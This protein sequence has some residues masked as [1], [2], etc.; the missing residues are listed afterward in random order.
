MKKAFTLAEVLIT[1]TIIGVIA[2]ITIPNLMQ[3]WEDRSQITALKTAYSLLNNAYKMALAENG[4]LEDWAWPVPNGGYNTQNSGYFGKILSQ[5]LKVQKYCG[6]SG[7]CFN[8]IN[9]YKGISGQNQTRSGTTVEATARGA[10]ILNNGMRIQTVATI[11][12]PMQ[13]DR[14][15]CILVDTNGTK[16][17]NQYGYDVFNLRIEKNGLSPGGCYGGTSKDNCNK[18]VHNSFDGTSCAYWVLRK[19]NMDYKYRDVSSEW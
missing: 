17:P 10:M 11:T 6:A 7:G 4:P 2:A 18:F 19:G 12:N 15:N 5:Y 8:Y 14:D 3:K 13:Y 9:Y 1:L 16:G